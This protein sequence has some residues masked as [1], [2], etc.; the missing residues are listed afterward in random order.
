MALLAVLSVLEYFR[1]LVR[2]PST[3]VFILLELV[4]SI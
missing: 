3:P 2:F 1:Y 4:A